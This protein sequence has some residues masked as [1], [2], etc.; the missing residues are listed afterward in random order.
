MRV[1]EGYSEEMW[2]F[3]KNVATM[4]RLLDYITLFSGFSRRTE[5]QCLE[6]SI[7]HNLRFG[8]VGIE[9]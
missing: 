2:H 3:R 7:D 8:L 4:Y 9:S 1:E 5:F 6:I